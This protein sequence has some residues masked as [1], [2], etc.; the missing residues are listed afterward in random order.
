M[1]DDDEFR[2]VEYEMCLRNNYVHIG[3]ITRIY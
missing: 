3:L 1:S 2:F